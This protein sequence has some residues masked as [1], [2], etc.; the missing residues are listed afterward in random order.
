MVR[1]LILAIVIFATAIGSG[2]AQEPMAGKRFEIHRVA[3]VVTVWSLGHS[4]SVKAM[5]AYVLTHGLCG[6]DD[7]LFEMG[8]AI[9]KQHPDVNVFVVDWSPGADRRVARVPNP[10]AAANRIDLT[11]DLLGVFLTK[12]WEAP[13]AR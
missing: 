4:P 6:I 5:H 8:Q 10:V 11:G 9:L 7:R 3:D 13:V 2:T 12:P 1:P